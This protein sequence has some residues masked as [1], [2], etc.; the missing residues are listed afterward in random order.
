MASRVRY[1][2]FVV[3]EAEKRGWSWAYWQFDSDF[4]LYD[5]KRQQWV[6]PLLEAI[7]PRR[8]N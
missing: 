7:Q 4:T 6:A 8:A 5:V 1:L 2:R 3:Q